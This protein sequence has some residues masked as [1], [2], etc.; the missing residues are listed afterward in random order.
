LSF[1]SFFPGD[2]GLLVGM[3]EAPFHCAAWEGRVTVVVTVFV[4]CD[5]RATL[6]RFGLLLPAWVALDVAMPCGLIFGQ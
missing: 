2:G 1:L 4:F 5:C 6:K 3:L